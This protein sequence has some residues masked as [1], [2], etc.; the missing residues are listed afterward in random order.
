MARVAIH[1]C[2]RCWPAKGALQKRRQPRPHNRLRLALGWWHKKS[3]PDTHRTPVEV[4]ALHDTPA[5]FEK[6][7]QQKRRE[8]QVIATVIE[9]VLRARI[10]RERAHARQP[11]LDQTG[12]AQRPTA[13]RYHLRHPPLRPVQG[14][15]EITRSIAHH[16]FR[17]RKHR[18]LQ[19]KQILYCVVVLQPVHTA[20][21][22]RRK[23]NVLSQPRA[24]QF[25]QFTHHCLTHGWGQ[26]RLWFWRHLARLQ[27]INECLQP[28]QI[29]R[30]CLQRIHLQQIQLPLHFA[31]LAVALHTARFENRQHTRAFRG[32]SREGSQHQAYSQPKSHP[33]HRLTPA[34]L[35]QLLPN[36]I[37]H[38]LI[39]VGPWSRA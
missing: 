4:L 30:Q 35:L 8:R 1:H 24:E 31:P 21:R 25:T 10:L 15:G 23:A 28:F 13:H 27:H 38:T 16:F 26:C 32:I 34:R 12:L 19:P 17:Q 14:F 29:R 33:A 22:R 3:F 2:L 5:Q 20:D 18:H 39:N 7:L 36:K 11:R 6:G 37:G 9:P